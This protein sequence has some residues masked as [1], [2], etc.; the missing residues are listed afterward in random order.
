MNTADERKEV[1]DYAARKCQGPFN[2]GVKF[3][4]DLSFMTEADWAE[5]DAR[6][7]RREIDERQLSRG[8]A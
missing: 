8:R 5:Y 1:D 3:A 4:Q 7:K 6:R 2:D